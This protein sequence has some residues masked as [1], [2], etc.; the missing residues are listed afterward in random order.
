MAME[1]VTNHQLTSAL[2]NNTEAED[3]VVEVRRK[4][5]WSLWWVKLRAD[6]GITFLDLDGSNGPF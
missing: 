4:L 6:K 1:G 3:D 5:A 2:N